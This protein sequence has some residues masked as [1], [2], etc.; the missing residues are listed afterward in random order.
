MEMPRSWPAAAALVAVAVVCVL[1][2]YLY[3][4][5]TLQLLASDPGV[6]RKHAYVFA[7]LALVCL[8]AA[9]FA[10]PRPA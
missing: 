6:H 7:G 10:R 1:V 5:G 4:V 2:A 8:V 9:N 3:Y